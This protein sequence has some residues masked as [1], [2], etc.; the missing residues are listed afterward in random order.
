MGVWLTVLEIMSV[1]AVVTNFAHLAFV[2][3]ETRAW[4]ETRGFDA[5]QQ[6]VLLVALEHVVIAVKYAI[7]MLVPAIPDKVLQEER[8]ERH[9]Q[10]ERM[11]FGDAELGGDRGADCSPGVLSGLDGSVRTFVLPISD[12]PSPAKQKLVQM[13]NGRVRLPRRVNA[14]GTRVLTRVLSPLPLGNIDQRDVNAETTNG[15]DIMPAISNMHLDSD[16]NIAPE[17]APSSRG[18]I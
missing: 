9:K 5:L 17:L 16:E 8:R 3:G 10:E 6:L 15:G 1:I 4:F 14:H 18:V 11:S 7:T 13:S 12:T 2:S